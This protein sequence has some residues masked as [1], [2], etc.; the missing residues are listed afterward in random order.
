MTRWLI[1]SMIAAQLMGC[2]EPAYKDAVAAKCR[3]ENKTLADTYS[4]FAKSKG[5]SCL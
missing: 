3:A 1:I 5:W 4:D 2:T